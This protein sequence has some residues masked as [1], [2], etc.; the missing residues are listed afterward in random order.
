MTPKVIASPRALKIRM[1][2]KLR[3][4]ESA[5]LIAVMFMPPS[6]EKVIHKNAVRGAPEPPLT[7]SEWQ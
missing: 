4:F 6:A 1:E 2:L 3:L 7:A 5:S